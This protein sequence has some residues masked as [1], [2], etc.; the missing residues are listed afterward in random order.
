MAYST[1]ISDERPQINGKHFDSVTAVLIEFK[2]SK[3]VQ[4]RQD[5]TLDPLAPMHK[6]ARN[7]LIRAR[8][9]ATPPS[10]PFTSNTNG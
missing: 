8:Q 6:I 4:I 9:A 1:G 5:N 2:Y 7:L 10:V 3:A